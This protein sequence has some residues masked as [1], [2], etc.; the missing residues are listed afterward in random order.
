MKHKLLTLV[1]AAVV[2]MSLVVVGCAKPAPTPAPEPAPA[3]SPAPTPAPSP[4]KPIKLTIASWE[5]PEGTASEPIR[6]WAKELEDR[7]GGRIDTEITYGALGP[8]TGYYDL[9]VDGIADVTYASP[10]YTPGKFKMS[11]MM[12]LPVS[13]EASVETMSTAFWQLYK[14]GYFDEDF[15]DVKVIWLGELNGYH[16]QMGEGNDILKYND[17]KGKKLRVSGAMHTKMAEAFGCN[18]VGMPSSEIFTSLMKGVIDGAFVPWSHIMSFRTESIIKS[19]TE[20]GIGGWEYGVFMNKKTWENLPDDIKA[21]IDDMSPKYTQM[22]G[23]RHDEYGEQAKALIQRA[24]GVVRQLSETD[25]NKVGDAVAPLWEEWIATK[26]AEGLPAREAI[27][28]FYYILK[29]MGIEMPY[30]GYTP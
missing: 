24:G 8:P 11:E 25:R 17:L 7:S 30:H 14:K 3:P 20:V 18:P 16:F 23:K 4:V 22:N 9:A 10:T 28:D 15:K 2:I 6:Q 29:D 5:P 26:E 1:L 21:I 19:I 27:D 13:G 12:E